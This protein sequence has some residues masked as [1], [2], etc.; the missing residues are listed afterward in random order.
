MAIPLNGVRVLDL[1]TEVAGPYATKLLADAGADVVKIEA[2]AGDPLRRWKASA[3]LGDAAPLPEGEDGA[4]FRFLNASKR[5]AVLDLETAEG[6]EALIGLAASADLVVESFVSGRMAE[7]GLSFAA[8]SAANPKLSLLSITP[9]G[10]DGPWAA[11]PATEFTLQAQLGS[12]PARGYSDRMPLSAG[13]RLG[14]YVS[15]TYASAGALAALR[16]ARISGQGEH[17][18]VSTCEA[19]LL[20]FQT[21]QYI[22]AQLEPGTKVG[23]SVETPSIEHAKDG[24]V[25][26][27]TITG[28]QWKDFTV[29]IDRPELG[30]DPALLA[31]HTRF[32]EWEKVSAA[33]NGWM[34]EH[35]VAEAVEK[36]ELLRVP[37]APIGNG[38]TVLE[39]DQFVERG[40]FEKN[41]AGFAQPR[42]PYRLGVGENRPFGPAPALGQ[43]T[44]EVV[45]APAKRGA[46]APGAP[47]PPARD[48]APQ[49]M[50]GLVVVD[51]TAFWAGPVATSYFSALG[52]D[53]V[54]I[55]SIQRPDGMRFAGGITPKESQ[56]LWELSPVVH[57]ANTNK[58]GITL[59]LD[60]EAGL[61]LAKRLIE[62]ADIVIEN[63]SPRVIEG[64]GLGWDGVH[65]LNPEAIMVRMPAFGLSGPWRDRT[66]FAMTIEQA[67]G[68]AWVTGYPDRSPIVP[69]GCCDPLGGMTAAFATLLALEVRRQ[70]GGGQ[71]VEVPLVE[72]GLN[73][74]AEQVAEYSAYGELLERRGNRGPGA[75]PQG[76]YACANDELIAVAV[77][78]DEQWRALVGALGAADFSADAALGSAQGRRAAQDAID[79]GLA[80]IFAERDVADCVDVLTKAGVPAAPLL[81]AR[82]VRPHPHLEARGFFVT[83]EHPEAGPIGYPS[84]PMRFSGHYLPVQRATHLLGEHNDEVLREKLG[85]SDDE[86]T[87]LRADKVIG[88]RPTF[89]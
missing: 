82:D 85:L 81:N 58:R 40:V 23:R 56:K 78:T 42:V 20:S 61:A 77:T 89:M 7:L 79:A 29:V 60:S 50:E 35:T 25:G 27:C 14:E 13:G 62:Q 38:Q 24:W 72:V 5:S 32:G 33:I 54:K 48:A 55:E 4:L 51:F 80:A 30:E 21:F 75:A 68:L 84:F 57:G 6:R 9:F 45:G 34:K 10:Q 44:S 53:V 15:G 74:A 28:Q 49:P 43:H 59:D 12:T 76:V 26:F 17:V 11:R 3:Q 41:P 67:T 37:V 70:G 69:R 83:H 64:F 88:E 86:L 65:A 87:K 16:A 36:A 8:L 31:A 52:A 71:L 18:D 2:P 39:T 63:F 47:A 73:A 66:G 1:S 46:S 22:H 19:M